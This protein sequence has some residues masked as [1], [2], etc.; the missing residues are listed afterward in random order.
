MTDNGTTQDDAAGAPFDEESSHSVTFGTVTTATMREEET[1]DDVLT[2]L[3]GM[4]AHAN[5]NGDGLNITTTKKDIPAAADDDDHSNSN[6]THSTPHPRPSLVREEKV[7]HLDIS[8][9]MA[10]RRQQ[11]IRQ[12]NA[13]KPSNRWK[14]MA[15]R[16]QELRAKETAVEEQ[17]ASG[18][19]EAAAA[20]A[21]QENNNANAGDAGDENHGKTKRKQYRIRSK[22]LSEDGK[23]SFG[24]DAQRPLQ[25]L[26]TDYLRCK[27]LCRIFPL[28]VVFVRLC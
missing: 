27:S 13:F 11:S 5:Q 3:P 12:V 17:A 21:Q 25:V 28:F 26:I 16:L 15:A 10:T 23:I 4:E 6:S 9:G 8:T 24:L 22:N 19:S 7:S 2:P 1:Y 14:K 18:E 20:Q